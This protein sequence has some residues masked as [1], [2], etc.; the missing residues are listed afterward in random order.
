MSMAEEELLVEPEEEQVQPSILD[1]IKQKGVLEGGAELL[2]NMLP[3][4]FVA[5]QAQQRGQDGYS[6]KDVFSSLLDVGTSSAYF[7]PIIGDALGTRDALNI[8][9][10]PD[11]DSLTK[12]MG[13]MGV[14]G[15]VPLAA[16][17]GA[18]VKTNRALQSA[19]AA[20]SLPVSSRHLFGDTL[21]HLSGVIDEPVKAQSLLAT[22]GDCRGR[23]VLQVLQSTD[24]EA[25][26]MDRSRT[27]D[28]IR[29]GLQGGKRLNNG[30]QAI[31]FL[32]TLG[33]SLVEKI[34][35]YRQSVNSLEL[36]PDQVAVSAVAYE[37]AKIDYLV[38]TNR[39][40]VGETQQNI[41][42]M[43]EKFIKG[44]ELLAPEEV[45]FL[46]D[47]IVDMAH[48]TQGTVHPH[49]AFDDI[50]FGL[51]QILLDG[52]NSKVF[53]QVLDHDG[54]SLTQLTEEATFKRIVNASEVNESSMLTH[55]S[56]NIVEFFD[57]EVRG[58]LGDGSLVVTSSGT[59]GLIDHTLSASAGFTISGQNKTVNKL[60]ERALE[61][62]G[63]SLGEVATGSGVKT[64][65]GPM[66]RGLINQVFNQKL[67]Q[68]LSPS[69]AITGTGNLRQ[70]KEGGTFYHSARG[71]TLEVER[72]LLH[73]GTLASA[74]DR[75]A[76]APYMGSKGDKGRMPLQEYDVTP[77][78]PYFPEGKIL[79]ERSDFG[80]FHYGTH[81]GMIGSLRGNDP[82]VIALKQA[83]Y[84]SIPYIN[85]VEGKG[86]ISYLILD[87]RIL[88]PLRRKVLKVETDGTKHTLKTETDFSNTWV[89]G[90]GPVKVYA[91]NLLDMLQNP[92]PNKLGFRAHPPRLSAPKQPL[93]NLLTTRSK[94]RHGDF[95]GTLVV[96][97][98]AD[99][100]VEIVSPLT[101][102]KSKGRNRGTYSSVGG[103]SQGQH[104]RLKV[105]MRVA[106]TRSTAD[107]IAASTTVDGREASTGFRKMTT[108]HRSWAFEDGRHI[109]ISTT[110]SSD[111]VQQH[112]QISL[113]LEEAGIPHKLTLEE[114]HIGQSKVWRDRTTGEEYWS[115]EEFEAQGVNRNN[116]DLELHEEPRLQI[117]LTFEDP[118]SLSRAWHI[119]HEPTPHNA[120]L[121][122]QGINTVSSEYVRHYAREY[123]LK[124][125]PRGIKREIDFIDAG[126]GTSVPELL[127]RPID[128]KFAVSDRKTMVKIAREYATKRKTKKVEAET[129]SQY[130]N[131]IIETD[132][133]F[134]WI[135]EQ[136]G[137]RMEVVD[138]NP[139]ASPMEMAA[140]I[141]DNKRLKVL[142][143]ESTGGHP[144][145]TNAQNDKFRF[146][147]DY[148]GHSALGNSFTRHGE[149]VAYLKHGQM[150]SEA[151]RGAMH[152]ETVGQNA[153]LVFSPE[154][155]AKAWK[156]L[157]HGQSYTGDFIDQRA[158]VLDKKY[159]SNKTLS[160]EAGY[161]TGADKGRRVDG[162]YNEEILDISAYTYGADEAPVGTKAV[163][164][165]HFEDEAASKL[166]HMSR[167]G[168][169]NSPNTEVAY[170]AEDGMY[171]Y[172]GDSETKVH[173]AGKGSTGFS[174][175]NG[176]VWW[177]GVAKVLNPEGGDFLDGVH[178]DLFD[179]RYK[180]APD[181]PA[182][183]RSIAPTRVILYIPPEG[184]GV[185]LLAFT[186]TGADGGQEVM[187][188]LRTIISDTGG[189]RG[190]IITL[191]RRGAEMETL[192]DLDEID[193][194]IVD[195]YN[196]FM[197]RTNTR[198][199]KPIHALKPRHL[200]GGAETKETINAMIGKKQKLPS[201][202][203][204]GAS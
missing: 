87:P 29:T 37:T 91:N 69:W 185:P 46:H 33:S 152:S 100:G 50:R 44:D 184:Q 202:P 14:I 73:V 159:W 107:R 75:A 196:H 124:I 189:D 8:W 121:S 53:I 61:I 183:F 158:I 34:P 3:G 171:Q 62:A 47:A 126:G 168:D 22:L 106:D 102:K 164:E 66:L 135:T 127:G 190:R 105:P 86:Q 113:L 153:W 143:T 16:S 182:E 146:V 9:D 191:T 186:G 133:Q 114:P 160:Q 63:A 83:G 156:A 36:T 128:P 68:N 11:A 77:N 145:L 4:S 122:V 88:K 175:Q 71:G 116:L 74:T 167:D 35:S 199:R 1:P 67:D 192:T 197:G 203:S 138:T 131:F 193:P 39:L 81:S 70:A 13:V 24:F 40:S 25:Q 2:G 147:H 79:D 65:T 23:K 111:A 137:V 157:R 115:V 20:S 142:S 173:Q 119:L 31:G 98:R 30:D 18:A 28:H 187:G 179:V 43:W 112:Q 178:K 104:V 163:F 7:T 120:D 51:D 85:K 52:P 42:P 96:A 169:V 15:L 181:T 166:I 139:Y 130:G 161:M 134:Q 198:K 154:N 162:I 48:L 200:T 136:A 38:K 5:N 148:F 118:D 123:G 78:K 174:K 49:F 108:N 64:I 188:R 194:F 93:K 10:D 82:I 32:D 101:G 41:I 151:A 57:Q 95:E 109:V 103:N 92:A 59:P 97:A 132:A 54:V 117:A 204:G 177:Q 150:Y 80:N 12:A 56:Q 155:E 76:F 149:Y 172:F 195:D 170:V 165:H 72:E 21:S 19:R 27:F 176:E 129:A 90:Q 55:F 140:D 6:V 144:L 17:A 84:D 110:Q 89:N 94:L 26:P 180:P 99:G 201:L 58:S 141:R 125:I 45:I 60:V